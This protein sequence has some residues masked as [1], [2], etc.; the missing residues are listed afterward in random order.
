MLIKDLLKD[1]IYEGGIHD[2]TNAFAILRQPGKDRQ[3]RKDVIQLRETS[4]PIAWLC[5]CVEQTNEK[6]W[7]ALD[8]IRVAEQ[9]GFQEWEL[10]Y[11]W[12]VQVSTVPFKTISELTLPSIELTKMDTIGQSDLKQ[13]LVERVVSTS[14]VDYNMGDMTYRVLNECDVDKILK[15]N[16]AYK[17]DFVS[18]ERDCDDYSR[19]TRGWLSMLG[20]GNV[21]IGTAW[22]IGYNN[23]SEQIASHSAIILVYKDEHGTLITK[24]AEPQR[25]DTLWH[26]DGTP[27][28]GFWGMGVTYIKAYELDF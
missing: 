19:I 4:K 23:K 8:I 28:T 20:Y 14:F 26:T 15:S 9:F 27:N 24:Y 10:L 2:P 1:Y 13:L 7:G 21:T 6:S 5:D 18:E 25:N 11:K 16:A 22:F 17:Y 12:L 3:L